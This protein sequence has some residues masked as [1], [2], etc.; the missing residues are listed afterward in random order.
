M[1]F[2]LAT[3][4]ALVPGSPSGRVLLSWRSG[5]VSVVILMSLAIVGL[6]S[7]SQANARAFCETKSIRDY[8][9]PL[10]QLPKEGRGL[11]ADGELP[12]GPQGLLLRQVG[13]NPLVYGSE[14]LGFSLSYDRGVAARPR[15]D[16]RVTAKLAWINRRGEV[17]ARLASA[18][19]RLGRGPNVRRLRSERGITLQMPFR[20]RTALY[21]LEVVFRN[22]SGAKL[23]RFVEHVRALR[24]RSNPELALNGSSFGPGETVFAQ[25]RELGSGWLSL[26]DTYSIERYDG[27]GWAQAPINPHQ[28]SILIGPPVG[29]G[30]ATS[31]TCWAFTVPAGAPPGSY[32][33]AVRGESKRV[34]AN[35]L[36]PGRERQLTSEFLILAPQD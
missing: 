16:W 19:R 4:S 8:E 9:K 35:R 34:R 27:A 12:F 18:Q 29:P 21:R 6:I 28:V 25:A 30:E 24:Y 14:G 20:F 22:R 17:I 13:G 10:K 23:G 26:Y 3:I 32:R 31:A 33:F 1:A 7:A 15:L 36:L 5:F 11:P 2:G